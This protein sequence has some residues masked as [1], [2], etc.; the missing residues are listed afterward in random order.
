[1]V[2]LIK[3]CVL[4]LLIAF[5]GV[6]PVFSQDSLTKKIISHIEQSEKG[7]SARAAE[8]GKLQYGI[9]GIVRDAETADSSV[10]MRQRFKN[11]LKSDMNL[12]ADS[13]DRVRVLIELISVNDTSSVVKLIRSNDG[14]IEEVGNH[15]PFIVCKIHPKKLRKL[16]SSPSV[17]RIRPSV[18]GYHRD[19][20]NAGDD[21]LKVD[22]ARIQFMV[23]G[24]GVNVGVI[25]DGVDNIKDVENN[26]ELPNV[27][28][29]NAGSGNEGTAMLEI[30]NDLAPSANLFFCSV[31]ITYQSLADAIKSLKAK[32]C[33]IIVDDIGYPDEPYFS[34]EDPILGSAIRDFIQNGGIYV[35]A[36][37]NDNFSPSNPS[38]YD[39]FSGTLPSVSGPGNLLVFPSNNTSLDCWVNDSCYQEIYFQWA[40]SWN[41]PTSDYDLYVYDDNGQCIDSSQNMQTPTGDKKPIEM[42]TITNG[43]KNTQHY[44]IVIKYVAGDFSSKDFKL[45]E[46]YPDWG[47]LVNSF[48]DNRHTYGHAG[49]PNVIGVAAYHADDVGELAPYSSGGPLTMFSTVLNQWTTQN[50]PSITAT[51]GVHTYV[52]RSLGYLK[53]PFTGTSAAAPHIAA[54]A[55]LYFEKFP[56]KTRDNF[57]ADLESSATSIG[58]KAG[59]GIWDQRAGYGKANALACFILA[60]SGSNPPV[61]PPGTPYIEVK[62]VS[63]TVIPPG[64]STVMTTVTFQNQFEWPPC[65]I[66]YGVYWKVDNGEWVTDRWGHPISTDGLHTISFSLGSGVHIISFRQVEAK[67]ATYT[68]VT[69]SLTDTINI[70]ESIAIDQKFSNGVTT[71]SIGVWENGNSFIKYPAPDTLAINTSLNPYHLLGTQKIVSGQKYNYWTTTTNHNIVTDVTNP[72]SFNIQTSLS[73]LISQLNQT[74]DSTTFQVN[75]IDAGTNY[76]DLVGFKDPWLIDVPGQYGLQNEGMSASFKPVT[77]GG[78]PVGTG[79]NYKGLITGQDPSLNAPA[80]YSVQVPPCSSPN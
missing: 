9:Y 18:E 37:G 55:A 63:P 6:N 30:V 11:R 65:G 33:K 32:Q 61:Y 67:T 14:V 27:T 5:I 34:D 49:Y 16:A 77:T 57:I 71:D 21:Q 41:H 47:M 53:D 50:T 46:A 1:M 25:S 80:Y 29:L 60:N 12:K 59:D 44:N 8:E 22:S 15:V 72:Q 40:T 38:G 51:S 64:Q 4:F 69:Y 28:V 58:G 76:P 39:M 31:Q 70:S 79:T 3:S 62:N 75:L 17:V 43:S 68:P 2:R 23:S 48:T 78:N 52:G 45:M 66:F 54:I 10:E 19:V 36:S 35:S 42:V 13:K 24:S 20:I 74:V 73:P 26:F 7:R 56:S